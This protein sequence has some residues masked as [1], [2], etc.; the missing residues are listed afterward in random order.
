M[1]GKTIPLHTCPEN[2]D[3]LFL[4]RYSN[5]NLQSEDSRWGT[6]MEM[7][8]GAHSHVV[9]H[10]VFPVDMTVK[11]MRDVIKVALVQATHEALGLHHCRQY[12]LLVSQFSKP[13]NDQT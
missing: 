10:A 6:G 2:S 1:A 5:I 13:I 4:M 9:S 7:E 12:L 11:A 3:S 8:G